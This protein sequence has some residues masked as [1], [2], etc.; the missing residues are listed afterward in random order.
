[1]AT[2]GLP[3]TGPT[4]SA[5]SHLE[6]ALSGS[7][8]DAERLSGL[9]PADAKPLLARYDLVR[10]GSTL[11]RVSLANRGA[12]GLWRWRELL[13]VRSWEFVVH[14][15]EGSTPLEPARRLGARLGGAP[16]A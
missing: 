6:G 11:T 4:G 3:P 15:G 14:M 2:I 10:A 9:D 1:M 8:Y 5:L 13:P 16:A 12:G 7:K